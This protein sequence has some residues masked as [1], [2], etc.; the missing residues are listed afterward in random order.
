MAYKRVLDDTTLASVYI[1]R[2]ESIISVQSATSIG[3]DTRDEEKSDIRATL[4]LDHLF[5]QVTFNNFDRKTLWQ[6]CTHNQT[7]TPERS[8]HASH[9]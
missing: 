8:M 2:S 1:P 5:L 7:M 3:L 4:T 6:R 9:M